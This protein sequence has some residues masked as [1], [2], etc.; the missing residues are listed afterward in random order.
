[1]VIRVAGSSMAVSDSSSANKNDWRSL[2]GRLGLEA[3]LF[4][5]GRKRSAYI[6]SRNRRTRL[7]RSLRYAQSIKSLEH[8]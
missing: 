4:L 1:M 6:K 2:I 5:Q 7:Q 3:A 8:L